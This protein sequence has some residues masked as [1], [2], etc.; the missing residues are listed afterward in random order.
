MSQADEPTAFATLN[1]FRPGFRNKSAL[2]PQVN[3]PGFEQSSQYL[4]SS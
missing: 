4:Q 2:Q 3:H 1:E